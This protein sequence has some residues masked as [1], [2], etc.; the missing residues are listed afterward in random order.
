MTQGL[1]TQAVAHFEQSLS[2][3]RRHVDQLPIPDSLLAL[4]IY[5]ERCDAP[6]RALD[7]FRQSLD[8]AEDLDKTDAAIPA[9]TGVG[10]ALTA[11]DD[12]ASALVPLRRALELAGRTDNP[13]PYLLARAEEGLGRALD[14]LGEDGGADHLRVAGEAYL[15]LGVPDVARIDA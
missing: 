5:H 9:L 7:Y 13:D 1:Y 12:P 3:W 2:L 11:S 8:A 6:A 14:A 4:G 15:H 10:R